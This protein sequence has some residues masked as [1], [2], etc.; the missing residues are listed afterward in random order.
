MRMVAMV[1]EV[2]VAS[3]ERLSG[4]L[5]ELN[6]IRRHAGGHANTSNIRQNIGRFVRDNSLVEK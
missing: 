3:K 6:V 2:V 4:R 1:V 5:K